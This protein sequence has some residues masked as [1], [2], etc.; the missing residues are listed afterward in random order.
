M[1]D[2]REASDPN[3]PTGKLVNWQTEQLAN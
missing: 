3:R 2:E 1:N